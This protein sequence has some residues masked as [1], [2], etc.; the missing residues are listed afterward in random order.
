MKILHRDYGANALSW[1]HR[2]ARQVLYLNH[3]LI[4]PPVDRHRLRSDVTDVFVTV[5]GEGD[6]G[7][8]VSGAKM[9][10]T[11]SALTHGTF[12]AQNSAVS[13]NAMLVDAIS[14]APAS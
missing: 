14:M 6:D 12:V 2:C 13:G 1:Y 9:V 11:G 8:R 7:I 3:V 4:D 5:T 10:A